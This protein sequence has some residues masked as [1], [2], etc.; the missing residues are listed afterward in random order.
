VF[1][2]DKNCQS[3][4]KLSKNEK[5][6]LRKQIKARHTLL[7]HEGIE[8]VF[9]A[10]QSLVVA[11]GGLGNGVSRNQLFPVLEKC[12][13]VDALLMPPNKP[14]SFVR[15][16][17]IEESKKAYD[18]LNGEEIVDDLGQKIILYLSFVEKAQWKELELQAL[19]PG[20]MVIEEIIS[21]DD[22]KML[23]ESVNWTEDTDNQNFQKSLKHRRVKHF[24]YEFHYENNNVDKDK[25]LP[26]GLPDICDSILEKWLKEGFIKHKPDQL[27]VNQYE[28][29]HGIPAHIDTHSAFEDEIISLSLGSEI[30]MD[31]KHPDG[32]TVP[33]MLPCRSLLVMTG[34]SRYLWTHYP[35]VCDSQMK[36]TS[37]SFPENDKEASQLE[38][39]YVHRVYEE[40]AGHFS[41]TR[42]T[43]WPHIVAFL[44]DL[45]SGSLV[46]DIGCGNGKYLGI[47]KELHMIGCDHSQNLVDICRERQYQAIVCDALSVPIRSGSCDACLSIAVIHHFA[48]AE[49]RVAA[50]QELVRLLRPGGKA[51]IY[52]WAME[53]EYKK[54]KSK[55]LRENRIS[56]GKKKEI[57]SHTPVE[58]LLVK[59]MPEV[60]NQD[61]ACSV[62]SNNDFQEGG[63]NSRKVTNSKLP[64]HTNRTSFHSQDLLV[65]WHL[66]GNP[67]KDKAVEPL[68]GPL[69][70]HDSGP[71]LHRYYHVFCEGELEA[72]SQTLSNV[73]ILQSYYDQGNWCVIL[74]KV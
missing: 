46:A 2:M 44:K 70:S 40:I 52:V 50:L 62:P 55:Y 60:G 5:K 49:R 10:T 48:T 39:E 33:V 45:P 68:C 74:Q 63:C 9:Y 61:A 57:S 21:S 42:H 29:G 51:L 35:L 47:N 6:L 17:T 16:T 69:G 38:Q 14:Y 11:N 22:E 34:E 20:L 64:I 41:S 8:T 36:A 30:V 1:A 24:G 31:F 43:P 12:G 7:R 28:P 58:E 71:V 25:P 56:Q 59:H 15:Y 23:L 66:K 3:N 72:A 67:G 26:G 19:P 54:K 53:Q 37:P 18:T 73:S 13:L 4:Y 27:T 65:P 32:I